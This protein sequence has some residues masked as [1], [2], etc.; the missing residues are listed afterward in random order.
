[1]TRGD[2]IGERQRAPAV[3]PRAVDR[4]LVAVLVQAGEGAAVDHRPSVARTV[5][6]IAG[7][8]ARAAASGFL[9]YC[10]AATQHRAQLNRISA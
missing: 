3:A 1:M 6:R 9:T 7:R 2:E 8:A 5:A 4:E 10:G